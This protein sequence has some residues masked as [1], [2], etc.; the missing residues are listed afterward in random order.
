MGRA[1]VG[2]DGGA[3]LLYAE[4]RWECP[5]CPATHLTKIAGPHV[6]Y[7]PCPGLKG[8]L[9]PYVVAGSRCRVQAV[10]RADY[11][12]AEKGLR[13]DGDGRPVMSVTTERWDGSNDTAVFAP[14][15]TA[16][17]G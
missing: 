16:R 6:P 11:V 13:Y 5:N 10:E 7:H 1:G 8:I 2:S 12:G 15:A 4:T 9:A 3:V 14:T 17:R